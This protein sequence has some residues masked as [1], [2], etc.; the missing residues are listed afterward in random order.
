MSNL[1]RKCHIG[2]DVSKA[3]LDVYIHPLGKSFKVSNDL[4]G[5]RALKKNLPKEVELVVM[6]ATGGYEQ[7]IARFLSDAKF[8]ISVV[9]PRQVRD[10]AKAMGTLAKTDKIDGKIIALFGERIQPPVKAPVEKNQQELADHRSRRTQLVEML[11]MEKNRL[12]KAPIVIKKSIEKTINFLEKE[13]NAIEQILR[14]LIADDVEWSK[15]DKLLRE[16]PGV[17]P[18]VSL[19]LLAALPELGKLNGKQ[20]SALV[21]VAPFNRDSGVYTGGRSVWGGRGSVRAVLYMGALVA[22]KTN[23]KI[24]AFYDRLCA[25]GKVKKV[26]LTACMRKLLIIMNA[27][28]KSGKAWQPDFV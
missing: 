25:A 5:M 7:A 9:N 3:N 10:F 18:T 17:G 28:I 27:M 24:K 26:A 23:V 15:K 22:S 2:I 19:T 11:V 4:K 14:K 13:L 12:S 20:I 21:G 8:P 1:E 6:E 16:I